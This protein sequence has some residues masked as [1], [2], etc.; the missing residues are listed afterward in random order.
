MQPE[1]RP[2]RLVRTMR[3]LLAASLALALLALPGQQVA[4]CSCAMMAPAEAAEFA[5]AVFAGTVVEAREVGLHDGP[6]GAVAATVPVP[7]PFG[8]VVYTFAVDGVAKGDVGTQA[9]ILGGGDGASCGM[10]FGL[11]ERWL[12]FATWDG[13]MLTTSL[14]A[15]NTVLAVDEQPPLPL[16]APADAPAEAA[17]L[18]VPFPLIA[19]VAAIGVVVAASWLAFRRG[20]TGDLAS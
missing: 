8:Q 1:G 18:E 11:D 10:S 9:E 15:G 13:V 14:C 12:V 2:G 16:T 7:A 20:P 4:A 3:F 6:L 5:D 17:E 19:V